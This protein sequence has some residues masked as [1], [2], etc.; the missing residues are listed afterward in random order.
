MAL[1]YKKTVEDLMEGRGWE[2]ADLAHKVNEYYELTG[3]DGAVSPND[4]YEWKRAENEPR[5]GLTL[6][7][8]TVLDALHLHPFKFGFARTR[9]DVKG[10]R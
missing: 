9:K 2:N 1:P 7:I 10:G 8:L 5:A 3:T 6:A 4:I